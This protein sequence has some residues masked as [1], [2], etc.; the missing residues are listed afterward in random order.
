M[1]P[2][3]TGEASQYYNDNQ[4]HDAY[5]DGSH[6]DP[7]NTHQRHDSND[8]GRIQEP[9]QDEPIHPLSQG[10]ST[11]PLNHENKEEPTFYADEFSATP[12]NGNPR[13]VRTWR[14]QQGRHLWTRGGGLRCLC[15]FFFCTVF[16]A[17][18][19]VIS[20]A[21]CLALWIR[22]PDI[23]IGSN[24][25]TSPVVTQ[26][27]NVVNDGIQVK[28]GL[29]VQVVNPNYFSAKLTH[30]TADIIYPINNTHI[31]NGTLSNVKL[32]SHTTT[33]FTFPFTIDYTES[34]DPT[35]AIITDIA[36]KCLASP[37]KDLTIKYELTVGV[38]VFFVSVSPTISDSISFTCPIS[39]SDLETLAKQLGLNLGSG[40]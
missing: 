38:K 37:Q 19:L 24:N 30:V 28:L 4:Q 31:G 33:S 2:Y 35:S 1:P 12:R 11:D 9:Y 21:L 6:F 26:G 40:S 34:I 13:N 15:R 20:I 32:P 17:L 23:I 18:F 29:P 3:A 36:A 5:Y 22:P 39:S 8:Q 14:Y 10:H 7:Y 16:I 27:V 25:N